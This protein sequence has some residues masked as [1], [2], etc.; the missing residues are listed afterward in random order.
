MYFFLSAPFPV[1]ISFAFT[2]YKHKHQQH[3]PLQFGEFHIYQITYTNMNSGGPNISHINQNYMSP[4]KFMPFSRIITR[5]ETQKTD[6]RIWRISYDDNLCDKSTFVIYR[7]SQRFRIL[8]FK[9]IKSSFHG[10]AQQNL[11]CLYF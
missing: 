8:I 2:K 6:F 11:P 5:T 9:V 7:I 1:F 4:Y 10:L 3:I